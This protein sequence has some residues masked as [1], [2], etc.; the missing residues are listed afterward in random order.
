VLPVVAEMLVAVVFVLYAYG[1]VALIQLVLFLLYTMLAYEAAKKKSA[2]NAKMMMVMFSEWGKLLSTANAYERAH[3]FD[4]VDYEVGKARGAF[5]YMGDQMLLV[6]KGEHTTKLVLTTVSLLITLAWISLIPVLTTGMSDLEL[7]ALAFYIFTFVG[8]LDEYAASVAELRSALFEYQTL[9]RFVE[10]QSCVADEEGCVELEAKHNP[11]IEF[12]NVSF[13]YAEKVIL[14]DVSFKVKGGGI[15][16][17]V[18]A[19]GCGKSTIMR[20]LMRFYQPSSGTITIDGHD[21]SKVSGRSLRRLFSVVTQDSQLFGGTLRANIEYGKAGASDDAIEH[22]AGLAEL[23]LDD[24]LCLGKEVGENG[25]KLSGGQQQRVAIARAMLKN[26]T[27]YLLD[28]PTTGLDGQTAKQLQLTLDKLA[29]HATTVTITHHL[30]DLRKADE[31]LYLENGKVI[32]RGTYDELCKAKGTFYK[33]AKA[34][35][36][37]ERHDSEAVVPSVP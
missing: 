8:Q 28:E 10:R 36:H 3:F 30:E 32:E 19:S 26:G 27:I 16:G 5:S 14:D 7:A 23:K 25:A 33:Q 17:L 15:L 20:L 34:R 1:P 21:V 2:R 11:E 6:T 4:R 9:L 37:S 31:I 22:A 13:S 12:K 24:D 18:G 35:R 29:T